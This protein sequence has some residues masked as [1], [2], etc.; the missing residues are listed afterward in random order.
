MIIDRSI[1]SISIRNTYSYI[2]YIYN[3]YTKYLLQVEPKEA[4]AIEEVKSSLE[5]FKKGKKKSDKEGNK[6]RKSAKKVES[7]SEESNS[8]NKKEEKEEEEESE[9]ESEEDEKEKKRSSKKASPKCTYSLSLYLN[10][11]NLYY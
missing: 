3:I 4:P 10:L 7:E 5:N 1:V 6:K 2:I 8:N 11:S 9:E